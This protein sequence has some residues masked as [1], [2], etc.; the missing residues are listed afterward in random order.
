MREEKDNLLDSKR[1]RVFIVVLTLMAIAI[2]AYALS[3]R[4]PNVYQL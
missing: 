3:V 1:A 4:G 2:L